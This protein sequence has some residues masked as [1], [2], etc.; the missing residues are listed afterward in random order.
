M[1]TMEE[2]LWDYIDGLTSGEE[3]RLLE[4]KIA[5]DAVYA[6]QYK[7]LL[8]VNQL[9]QETELEEPSMSFTRNVMSQVAMEPQPLALKTKVDPRVI[10]SIAAMFVLGIFGLLFYTLSN[11][12]LSMKEMTMPDFQLKLNLNISNLVN[13]MAL[14][15]FFCVDI[16]LALIYLDRVL[17]TRSTSKNV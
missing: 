14:R 11:S 15:V 2:Q 5:T 1:K 17:R 16:L 10:Y 9:L 4:E 3:R 8:A 13:P 7:A 6:E 12:S